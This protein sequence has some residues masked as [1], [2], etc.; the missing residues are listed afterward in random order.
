MVVGGLYALQSHANHGPMLAIDVKR[1]WR[2]M[3]YSGRVKALAAND[4]RQGGVLMLNVFFPRASRPTAAER[5]YVEHLHRFQPVVAQ[6]LAEGLDWDPHLDAIDESGV[7]AYLS[8]PYPRSLRP[9]AEHIALIAATKEARAAE[10]KRRDERMAAKE[11]AEREAEQALERLIRHTLRRAARGA[12]D[13]GERGVWE[14]WI[15]KSET[16]AI[17]AVE[18][19][20]AQTI[21]AAVRAAPV[22]DA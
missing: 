3:N 5:D 2:D 21:I 19:Y 14:Y 10:Q 18:Q 20:R 12:L 15:G 1:K 4:A 16:S 17:E 13:A 6:R 22:P 9:W 11:Q 8:A 7:T